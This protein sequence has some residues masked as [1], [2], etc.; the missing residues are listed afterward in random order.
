[1]REVLTIKELCE[2]LWKLENELK[3]LDKEIK[4]IRFWELTRFRVFGELSQKLSGYGQAHTEKNKFK[5]KTINFF[6]IVKNS[7][8]RNP[9]KGKYTVDFILYD[10]PRKV[11]VYGNNIDIYTEHFIK[12][13]N[14]K[15]FD[16]IERPQLWKHKTTVLK[17]NRKYTDHEILTSYLKKK[18]FPVKLEDK[19]LRF[20]KSLKNE[21]YSRFNIEID[22]YTI[23][24]KSLETFIHRKEYHKK[25][26]QK[27]KPKSIYVVVSYSNIPIIAAA[28]ELD[29][30]VIEFQHGVITDYHFAYN[31]SD[32]DKNLIYFP[33]K[34][35]TF[36]EYW[37]KTKGLPNQIEIE[38]YGFPYLNEQLKKYKTTSK[39]KNQILFISQGTIGR[40][41]SEFALKVAKK[42]PEYHIV[43]KL[44][45]GE[46]DRWKRDYP[47]LNSAMHL[48]N[49][50]I[51]DNNKKNLYSFL[52][53]SEYQI[54]V[55]ST[56]IFE[57]LALNCK[58]LLYKLPGIE[59][60]EDL[61]N[62]DMV[63]LVH[64][65]DETAHYLKNYEWKGFPLEYFF[66]D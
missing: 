38:E 65:P 9:F 21:I 18:M 66:K 29:I 1:M 7:I 4:G 12:A 40:D 16:V 23:I 44:H 15:K 33:D 28:K 11:K 58:T 20:I 60:M 52:A 34:L 59:Y 27:R 35:L 5:D 13:H 37:G 3:L 2:K 50:D 8:L 62:Q 46:Y 53:A 10:H 42:I 63:K 30:K 41:L 45:P 39:I 48:D 64:N 6:G 61:I 47:A 56:A 22:I 54:G 32:P 14:E 17:K 55:Y 31:Y 36:G 57:G 43:Y 26:F 51:I 25:L 19:D 24:L 49:F